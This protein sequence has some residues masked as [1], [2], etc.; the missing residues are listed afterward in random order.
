MILENSLST[1]TSLST[2]QSHKKDKQRR[3]TGKVTGQ[4]GEEE[5]KG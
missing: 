5:E 2:E 1:L 3:G 4:E